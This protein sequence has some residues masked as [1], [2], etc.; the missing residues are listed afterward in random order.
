MP[1]Y[2]YRCT[3]CG[4]RFER[5]QKMSD[6]DP[7]QCPECEKRHVERLISAVGFRL[8]GGGWYETDF[9]KAHRH[10]IAGTSG[11]GEAGSKKTGA[12]KE[13]GPNKAPGTGKAAG[14]TEAD[15]TPGKKSEPAA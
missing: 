1:I 14:K 5:W 15:K 3:D 2:E 13:E 10:N 11:D 8:K 12:G 9:K 7:D 4:H 6:P